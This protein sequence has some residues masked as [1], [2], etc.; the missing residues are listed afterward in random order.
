MRLKLIKTEK[1]YQ[2][3]LSRVDE[4]F[5]AK[6][7]TPEGDE[8]EVLILLIEDYEAKHYPIEPPNDPIE[9]IKFHLNRLGLKQ[10]DFVKIIGHKST[11]SEILNKKTPLSLKNIRKIHAALD[12]SLESLVQPYDLAS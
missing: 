8:L 12:V 10:S 11:A 3:A 4:I 9:S 2:T 6:K 7:N 5:E 1:Q